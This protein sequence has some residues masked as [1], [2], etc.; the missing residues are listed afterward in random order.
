MS[1]PEPIHYFPAEQFATVAEIIPFPTPKSPELARRID[2]EVDAALI[3]LAHDRTRSPLER[4]LR[5]QNALFMQSRHQSFT[6]SV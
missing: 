3:G 1:L 2:R 6:R 5:L 4:H